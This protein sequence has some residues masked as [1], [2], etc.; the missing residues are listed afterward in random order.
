MKL[1]GSSLFQTSSIAYAPGLQAKKHR[2]Q[3]TN[4][5]APFFLSFSS[6]QIIQTIERRRQ[7]EIDH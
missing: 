6:L 2:Q 1:L 5:T 4:T 3:Y 7:T